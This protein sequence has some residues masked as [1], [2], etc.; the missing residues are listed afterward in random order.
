MSFRTLMFWVLIAIVSLPLSVAMGAKSAK[1]AKVT[2]TDSSKVVVT[3]EATQ[4]PIASKMSFTT[5]PSG[6]HRSNTYVLGQSI[7][8]EVLVSGAPVSVWAEM[9][10]LDSNFP[11]KIFFQNKS[12][13]NW[14]L[15]VPKLSENLNIGNHL[16][17]IFAQDALGKIIETQIKIT[18]QSFPAANILSYKVS[19]SGSASIDWNPVAWADGYLVNWQIQGDEASSVFKTTKSHLILLE[20]L[21]P[22]TFYQVKIQ[23]LRGDAVGPATKVSFKT[24]GN[25]PV[26]EVAGVENSSVTGAREVRQIVPSIDPQAAAT[27]RIAQDSGKTAPEVAPKEEVKTSPSPAS[28]EEA[29]TSAGGWNKLL[30]AL[31]ILIIAAGAAIGGYYGYEWLVAK[32]KDKKSDIDTDSTDRW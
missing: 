16:I 31:S 30:V 7:N 21:L 24:L 29:A 28:E 15:R 19:G 18:L 1:A 9:G 11:Q 13:G 25:A 10:A 8:M 26:R 17:K 4:K 12:Q 14:F 5:S 3:A 2:K 6:L 20:N 32:S 27:K 23:P 22:G